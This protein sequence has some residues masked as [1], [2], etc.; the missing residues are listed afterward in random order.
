MVAEHEMNVPDRWSAKRKSKIVVRLL[1]A[2]IWGCSPGRSRCH[3][4]RSSIGDR[5]SLAGPRQDLK[6]RVG[7]PLEREI[8]RTQTRLGDTMM[9]LN[10]AERLLQ[11]R[12]FV[13]GLR[14]L[15]RNES[16]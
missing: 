4:P 13:A 10:L 2:K 12:G 1:R 16:A 8:T 5:I 14:R 15:R 11:N 7:D 6:K 9:T 3:C